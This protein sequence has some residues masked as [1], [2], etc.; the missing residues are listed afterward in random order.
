MV[1]YFVCY[2]LSVDEATQKAQIQKWLDLLGPSFANPGH[3]KVF[4]SS[5]QLRLPPLAALVVLILSDEG[6]TA[7][8]YTANEAH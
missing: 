1:L 2:D 8:V 6:D 5:T 7:P 3:R 4:L